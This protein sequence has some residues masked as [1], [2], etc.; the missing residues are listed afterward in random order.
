MSIREVIVAMTNRMAERYASL[1][2]SCTF[3]L[4]HMGGQVRRRR[5]GGSGGFCNTGEW[6]V[7]SS[8]PGHVLTPSLISYQGGGSFTYCVIA[9]ENSGFGVR[10]GELTS[11]W[12]DYR[13]WSSYSRDVHA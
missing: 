1:A 13:R 11:P 10:G 12:I 9:S 5:A 8:F 3:S 2:T 4:T 7:L 6:L